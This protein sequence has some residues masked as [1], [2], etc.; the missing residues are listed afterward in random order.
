[1]KKNLQMDWKAQVPIQKRPRSIIPTDQ[2]KLLRAVASTCQISTGAAGDPNIRGIHNVSLRF[3]CA[4][5]NYVWNM[6]ETSVCNHKCC[7]QTINSHKNLTAIMNH[8]LP[9]KWTM[10]KPQL[11]RTK[12][13][14]NWSAINHDCN[15]HDQPLTVTNDQLTMINE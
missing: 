6:N 1:M 11:C 3:V 14:T 5:W 13:I 4:V 8:C 15:D 7:R 10:M 12:E 9:W 2:I